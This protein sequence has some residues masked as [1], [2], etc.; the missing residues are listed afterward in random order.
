MKK[1]VQKNLSRCEHKII[2]IITMTIIIIITLIYEK[3]MCQ[4]S[5]IRHTMDEKEKKTSEERT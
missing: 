1:S 4:Q 5:D 2:I 3:G